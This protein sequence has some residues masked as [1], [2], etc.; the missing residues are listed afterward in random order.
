MAGAQ[1]RFRPM[2]EAHSI[3][4]VVITVRFDRPLTDEAIRSA[5]ETMSSLQDALPRRDSIQGMAF[6]VGPQGVMPIAPPIVDVPNGIARTRTDNGGAL[7]KD[8]RIDRQSIN[9]RTFEYTR[10]E[11]VWT[12][13]REY[14]GSLLPRLGETN[15][16]AYALSYVDK[17]VWTGSRQTCRPTSLLK[18]GSLYVSPASFDADD[19]WHC[20]SGRFISANGHTKRLEAV[21]IDCVDENDIT[22]ITPQLVRVVRISTTLTD[23]LNQQGFLPRELPVTDAIGYLDG[24]AQEL[25]SS[26]KSMFGAIVNDDTADQVGLNAS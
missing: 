20:H 24:A 16:A 13:A 17:F 8:L 19:L 12:E 3:E 5:D 10:W 26:L 21:N 25:H 22:G 9:F 2:H 4:Q 14:F 23:F 11:A 6:Q 1:D 15:I 7:I 18:S